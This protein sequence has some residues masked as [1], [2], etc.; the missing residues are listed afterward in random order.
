MAH[1]IPSADV[2]KHTKGISDA[3]RTQVA[4]LQQHIQNTLG[5]THHTF[6]QGSYKNETSTSDINDVDIV[7]VRKETYSSVHTGLS[8]STSIPWEKIFTEIETKLNAQTLYKWTVTRSKSGKCIEVRTSDFKADVV[9]AVQINSD[10]K[11]DPIAIYSFKTGTEKRN[12]PRTHYENGVAK[13][14]ETEQRYKPAVRMFKN[15]VANHFGEDAPLSSY[16]MESLVHSSPKDN[17]FDDHVMS[18]L[19][20]SMHILDSLDKND[21]IMSVCGDEDIT[22][23]WNTSKRQLFKNTLSKA[24]QEAYK[25]YKATTIQDAKLSWNNAF[26]L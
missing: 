19:T 4:K 22:A 15:W 10:I 3:K 8:F 23:N 7:A 25:G 1:N 18:F 17:F 24:F 13:H 5:S 26:N 21:P 16:Q 11:S 9:P 2:E 20:I 12:K 6:L 14:A